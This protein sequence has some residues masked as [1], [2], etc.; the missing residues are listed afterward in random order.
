MPL[1]EHGEILRRVTEAAANHPVE[2]AVLYLLRRILPA[3]RYV[4]TP[5][6]HHLHAVDAFVSFANPAGR[7]ADLLVQ[8]AIKNSIRYGAAVANDSRFDEK[9]RDAA[10]CCSETEERCS[11]LEARLAALYQIDAL[12]GREGTRFSCRVVESYPS[13]ALVLLD[14]GA[15]ARIV[16]DAP[17]KQTLEP[18]ESVEAVLKSAL[19]S[20]LTVELKL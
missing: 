9:L 18:G 14:N 2:D 10:R 16:F 20:T 19:F 13:G 5:A 1:R 3:A 12:H 6:P 15:P 4:R 17:G 7:Y 11:M 8:R